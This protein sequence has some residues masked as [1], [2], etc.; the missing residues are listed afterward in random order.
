[1][2]TLVVLFS[3]PDDVEGFDEHYRTTHKPL[4]EAV[5]GSSWSFTRMT[6][7]PGGGDPAYYLMAVGTFPSNEELQAG[8]RSDE[9]R[10]TGRDAAQMV[11]RFGIELTMLIGSDFS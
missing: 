7:T 10:E 1:V 5:P 8:M 11:Q 9:M 4:A 2:A 6:G 3:R